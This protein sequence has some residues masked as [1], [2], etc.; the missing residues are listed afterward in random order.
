M[1][2]SCTARNRYVSLVA[3]MS[4]VVLWFPIMDR[5]NHLMSHLTPYLHNASRLPV[6]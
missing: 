5:K 4:I 6:A 1:L 3:V 2:A